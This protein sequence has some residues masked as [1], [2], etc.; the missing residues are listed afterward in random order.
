ML[1]EEKQKTEHMEKVLYELQMKLEGKSSRRGLKAE[2]EEGH[3]ED[4]ELEE[5]LEG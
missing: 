3:E 5:T 1:E 2:T 4:T